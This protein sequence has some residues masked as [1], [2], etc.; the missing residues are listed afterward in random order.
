[1]RDCPC[2]ERT[3]TTPASLVFVLGKRAE[4]ASHLS[5]IGSGGNLKVF[6]SSGLIG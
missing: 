4:D 6:W 2:R 1:M 5:M 3:Q